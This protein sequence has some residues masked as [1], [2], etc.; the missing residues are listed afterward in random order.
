MMQKLLWLTLVGLG[1]GLAPVAYAGLLEHFSGHYGSLEIYDE[2]AKLS[3]R[4]NPAALSG[5]APACA[6]AALDQA[7]VA[8]ST[9]KVKPETTLV[10]DK[11]KFPALPGWSTGWQR[12]QSLRTA[13]RRQTPW[14]FESLALAPGKSSLAQEKLQGK[15]APLAIVEWMKLLKKSGLP[16]PA[17]AQAALV[18]LLAKQNAPAGYKMVSFGTQCEVS[19]G[20]A[21][22]WNVGY[23]DHPG[24]SVYF[25]V[26]LEGKN[27]QVLLR[28]APRI[29]DSSLKELKYWPN[30]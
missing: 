23:V 19:P 15:V 7:L 28:K 20:L 26:L 4:V 11:V 18:E 24:G 25:S 29:R 3:F 12:D 1:L 21:Q 6:I 16:Y 17:S 5:A 10:W 2:K 22:S 30:E 8:L 13:L 9:Q 27:R 14:F